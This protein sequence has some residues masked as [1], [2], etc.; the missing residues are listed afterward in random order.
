MYAKT[1]TNKRGNA[2][3]SVAA[4]AAILNTK[5]RNLKAAALRRRLSEAFAG[6]LA[7]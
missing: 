5:N 3:V 7:S 6:Y 1:I 4:L 2:A